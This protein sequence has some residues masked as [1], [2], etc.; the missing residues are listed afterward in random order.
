M[1]LIC[2]IDGASRGNPGPAGIGVFIKTGSGDELLR[3][4]KSIGLATNNVAEYKALILALEQIQKLEIALDSVEIRSDS[5]LLVKQM[6]GEYRIKNPT[7]AKLAA[8]ANELIQSKTFGEV[9]FVHIPRKFNKIADNL[10]NIGSSLN[11]L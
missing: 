3:K 6:Q 4:S 11:K 2:Y 1:K 5:Q 10:A 8:K 7:L 9:K